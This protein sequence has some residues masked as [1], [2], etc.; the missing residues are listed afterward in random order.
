MPRIKD[1]KVGAKEVANTITMASGKVVK[2]VLGYRQTVV[3]TWDYV[4]AASIVALL[5]LLK[6]NAFVYVEYPSPE[7]TSSGVFEVAYPTLEVFAYKDGVAAWHN[8]QLSMSG[9]EVEQ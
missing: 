4:P 5:A 8:V 6:N 1:V 2:D 7:G 9:Q 3:A